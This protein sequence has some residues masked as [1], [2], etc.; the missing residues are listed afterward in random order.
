MNIHNFNLN[1]TFKR[2]SKKYQSKPVRAAKYSPGMENGFMVYFTNKASEERKVM[3]YEGVKFFPTEIEAWDYINAGNKQ[4]ISEK[5]NLVEI[6]VEYDP[7]KPVLYRR[8][9]DTINKDGI[10][11]CFGEYSFVSDE[12]CDYEFFILEDDCWIIQEMDGTIRVWYPDDLEETFFGNEKDI[13]YERQD[14][15]KEIYIQ[16]KI[17]G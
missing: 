15:G 5:G 6:A 11:L 12:S 17:A 3:M 10:H 16:T 8:D 4:Y 2:N 14:K 13:V 1:T 9:D 7:P